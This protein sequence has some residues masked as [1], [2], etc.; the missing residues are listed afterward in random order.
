MGFTWMELK[1]RQERER[2][3]RE[4][5]LRIFPGG[6]EQKK[7]VEQE[8]ALRLPGMD[9]KGVMLY[10]ILIRDAMTGRDG[11]GFEM[12]A[13]MA[14]KKQHMVKVTPGIIAAV[15]AVMEENS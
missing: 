7:A 13:V 15:K 5:L 6:K 10:Y 11:E 1:S 12:A 3:E 4:Y 9:M 14:M 8:L 2:D